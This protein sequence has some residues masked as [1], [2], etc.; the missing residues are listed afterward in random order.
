MNTLAFATIRELRAKLD[1][2]Q[3]SSHDVID[4]FARRF[5]AFDD[6]IGSALE[7]FDI[8]S[9]EKASAGSGALHGIP[10]LIKD[11]ILQ[12]GRIATCGSRILE[13]Y[14]AVYDSTA[15]ARLKQW[16][17]PLIGRANMDEFAMGSSTETSAYQK[18]KNPW[19][20]SRVP[21]GSSG[22]SA[23]AVAAGLVPWSLGSETGGSVRQP[24]AFCGITGLKPTYGLISRY[25]LVA[26]ASSLDQIGI[27]T[28]TAYDNAMVLSCIAGQD[29]HDSSTL[30][31][32][33]K[34]YTAT[35][36]GSLRPNLR[37]GV[38]ENAIGA[39][40]MDDEIVRAIE[41]A[42]T[43][44]EKLGAQITRIKLPTLD[45]S[46]AAYFILSRAEAASNLSRF[47]GVRYGLRDK[48]AH[49]L[50]A[51]YAN[52]RKD[53]FGTEVKSRILIGNYVLSSGHSDQYYRKAELVQRAI[54]GDFSQS[55]KNVDLLIMPTH[56]AP[57]FKFDA[58][59]VDKLQMDLQDYFTCAMNLA[60]IP[61]LA[62]PCGFTT[63]GLPIGFQLAGPHLSE[64]LLFSTAH[65]Y[66][67]ATDW[68]K[69]HP[70]V[71]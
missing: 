65:A 19:D 34:D 12:N 9:I 45:Y 54:R 56:P 43:E 17:A 3:I 8:P 63:T 24:A 61:A 33:P 64:E 44:F 62:L 16:G 67:E 22:G 30:P 31:V 15:I 49:S 20:T 60:G 5:E 59:D 57:A 28:H 66:Q 35:L 13:N 51:M 53:G 68:H 21:G 50:D 10:G 7:I 18:T 39:Q 38:V 71:S 1:S 70:N 69:K 27:F 14:Q 52:T 42:V 23:A 55:F 29:A 58:F 46:A 40:G 41:V 11:N 4:F 2:K 25:G 47:D 37:I 32:A 26:Y 6:S 48:K 36:T